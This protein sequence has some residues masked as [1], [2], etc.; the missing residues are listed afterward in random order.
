[1][2]EK[3]EWHE[4]F[5]RRPTTHRTRTRSHTYEIHV[6]NS[7]KR[8]NKMAYRFW[9]ST[10]FTILFICVVNF[11]Q[12]QANTFARNQPVIW[13]TIWKA[14]KTKKKRKWNKSLNERE[15]FKFN[16][17]KMKSNISYRYEHYFWKYIGI[18]C[19]VR[20]LYKICSWKVNSDNIGLVAGQLKS[21]F[22]INVPHFYCPM[23]TNW[24]KMVKS[25]TILLFTLKIS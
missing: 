16:A 20:S 22:S 2:N 3:S 11:T 12:V 17:V 21:D 23:P 4:F 7:N 6:V 24:L 13:I 5:V 8:F 14:K 10:L 1:M 18:F 15:I 19:C 9:W 25:F